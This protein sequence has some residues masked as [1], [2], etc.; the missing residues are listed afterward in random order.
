MKRKQLLALI[1]AAILGGLIAIFGYSAIIDSAQ[2]PV[3][4]QFDQPISRVNLVSALDTSTDFTYAAEHT[5]DGV[6]HVTTQSTVEYRNPIYD[7]FYG[8]R[9]DQQPQNVTAYGS[10]VI[11]SKDGYIVTNNHVIENSNSIS[12]V[13]NDKREFDAKLIGTDPSTDIALLKVEADDLPYIE[14]GNSD[15]LKV[16]EWVLA[17]GNPFNINSTVTAGI[18]SA[19]GRGEMNIIQD[20]YSIESFIQTDAAINRGNSGGALVNLKGEMV[21]ITTAIASPSGGSVGISFAVPTSIVEKVAKDL[22]E[23]GSIQRA[24]MGVQIQDINAQLAKEKE[25]NNLE[26]VYVAEVTNGSAAEDAGIKSGDVILAIN[27]VRVNSPGGLQEQ[28]GRHRPGDRVEVSVKRNNKTQQFNVVLR[29]LQGSTSILKGD[30]GTASNSRLG[31]T[32]GN[33]TN[34]ERQKLGIDGG[35]KV[36]DL[37]EGILQNEGVKEGF[38]ITAVNKQPVNS[39]D[40]LNKI[41]RN[42][43]G[44]VLIEGV[45]PDGTAAYYAFGL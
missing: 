27:G 17:V 42:L 33:I 18:V 2:K 25:I 29:N 31:A 38:V 14:F 6:V 32:F 28:I 20:D 34:Q 44:G 12:V 21:G 19:K 24:I 9:Y 16:G 37:Q 4:S 43:K 30:T 35:V 45:Y 26:G 39:V 1:G 40:E 41:L 10:G 5:I 23:Y 3:L 22:K 11:I 36:Q 8:D 13:L 15:D 7:F